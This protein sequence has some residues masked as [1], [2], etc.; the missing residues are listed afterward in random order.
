MVGTVDV[1]GLLASMSSSLLD[2]WKAYFILDPFGTDAIFMAS[3]QIA[4]AI[5]N[6]NRK[7]G[8]RVI[9]P[10]ELIPNFVESA[11][12]YI[13][14]EER[15]QTTQEQ[16]VVVEMLNARFGGKDLRSKDG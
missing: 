12:K 1:D 13:L 3:A 15:R 5:F 16:L 2:E 7:K 11:R 6:T 10:D 4:S 9:S 14:R 8:G